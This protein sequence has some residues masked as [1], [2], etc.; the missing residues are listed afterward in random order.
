MAARADPE[1]AG[2]S[3]GRPGKARTVLPQ[4]NTGVWV[5]ATPEEPAYFLVHSSLAKKNEFAVCKCVYEDKNGIAVIRITAIHPETKELTGAVV[6]PEKSTATDPKCLK[7]AWI[8]QKGVKNTDTNQAW[9][10]IAYFKNLL[11]GGK[12]PAGVIKAITAIS[13]WD[14]PVDPG[15]K[16]G[17]DSSIEDGYSEDDAE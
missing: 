4:D 5:D 16:P 8:Q 9:S 14:A 15:A 1:E 10:V 7:M 2:E 13:P 6:L 17:D 12:L 3:E 11:K